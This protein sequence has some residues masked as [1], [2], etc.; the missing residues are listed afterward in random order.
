MNPVTNFM[1]IVSILLA[2]AAGGNSSK[3][4]AEASSPSAARITSSRPGTGCSNWACTSNHNE[5][6]LRDTSSVQ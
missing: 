6:L 5:T 2:L 4:Q 3:G 1:L